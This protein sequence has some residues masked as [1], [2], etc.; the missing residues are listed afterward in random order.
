MKAC[1]GGWCLRR[2]CCDAYHAGN[3]RDPAERLCVPGEDGVLK[4]SPVQ[5]LPQ[6]LGEL[7]EGATV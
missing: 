3:R 7:I 2:E 5:F 4:E 6:S 1:M